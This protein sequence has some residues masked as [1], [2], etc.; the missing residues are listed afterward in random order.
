MCIGLGF[1]FFSG[2]IC[3]QISRAKNL[4]YPAILVAIGTLIGLIV[5]PPSY[6]LGTEP[7][8]NALSAGIVMLGASHELKLRRGDT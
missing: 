2:K 7:S 1:S 5:F 8:L 3:V 4:L 6:A